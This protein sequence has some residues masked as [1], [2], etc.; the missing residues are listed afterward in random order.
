M[1]ILRLRK[2]SVIAFPSVIAADMNIGI[3]QLESWAVKHQG[4]NF[5]FLFL[6]ANVEADQSVCMPMCPT[7]GCKSEVRYRQ[8][9][10]TLKPVSSCFAF[11]AAR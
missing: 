8:N 6:Q 7:K 1:Y 9:L 2:A 5:V 3:Y 4:W 10:V 11:V